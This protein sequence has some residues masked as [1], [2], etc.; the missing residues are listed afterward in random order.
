MLW[1]V[2][3]FPAALAVAGYTR[4]FAATLNPLVGLDTIRHLGLD[5]VKILLMGL[6]L[7][8]ASGFVSGV[9]AVVFVAF[10]MPGVGNIPAKAVGSLFGFYLSVVFSCVIAFALYKAADRLKLAR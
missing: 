10:D 5:Y 4:S 3:Y 1:G 6:A 9:L 7:G 2:F 8:V